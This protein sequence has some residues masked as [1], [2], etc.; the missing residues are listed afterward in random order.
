MEDKR[1]TLQTFKIF[2]EGVEPWNVPDKRDP[3]D[4]FGILFQ[5]QD[6]CLS[7]LLK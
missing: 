6:V 4:L 2:M 1:P 3:G 5:V 7:K